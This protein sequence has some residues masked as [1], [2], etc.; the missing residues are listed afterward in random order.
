MSVRT[1]IER[2]R[3]TRRLRW[4]NTLPSARGNVV[5]RCLIRPTDRDPSACQR[6]AHTIAAAAWSEISFEQSGQ[7]RSAML[8]HLEANG[9]GAKRNAEPRDGSSNAT[10]RRLQ[11]RPS[12]RHIAPAGS[13]ESWSRRLDLRR[14]P[15]DRRPRKFGPMKWRIS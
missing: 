2:S 13:I 4:G 12:S 11:P 10:P 14:M 5:F 9:T 7:M 1:G 6:K 15:I 3:S 8:C